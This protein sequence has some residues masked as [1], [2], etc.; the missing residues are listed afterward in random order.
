[1]M[2][3]L[4][5]GNLYESM[6]LILPQ[7]RQKMEEYERDINMAKRQQ[8]LIS[9]HQYA[10]F[11]QTISDAILNQSEIEVTLFK[12]SGDEVITGIPYMDRGLCIQTDIGK[13]RIPTERVTNVRPL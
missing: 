6:R 9:E 10:E 4:L 1:M 3:S 12:K 5:D 2:P 13:E 7:H 8:P 11:S